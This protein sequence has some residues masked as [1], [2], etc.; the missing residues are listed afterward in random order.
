MDLQKTE[1]RKQKSEVR[2]Q[3]LLYGRFFKIGLLGRILELS[4]AEISLE[5]EGKGSDR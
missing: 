3:I 5:T 1:G 2:R 4:E